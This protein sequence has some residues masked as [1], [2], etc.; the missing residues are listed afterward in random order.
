MGLPKD[1]RQPRASGSPHPKHVQQDQAFGRLSSSTQP[2]PQ[3]GAHLTIRSSRVRFAASFMRYRVTHRSAAAQ[4]GLTQ[5][6]GSGSNSSFCVIAQSERSRFSRHLSAADGSP[7]LASVTSLEIPH[8]KHRQQSAASDSRARTAHWHWIA[9]RDN[10]LP[11]YVACER[12]RF[13][14]HPALP[15]YS[16]K[17]TPLRSFTFAPALR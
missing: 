13:A 5:V 12:R 2:K 14:R 4:P 10:R 15:N 16:F 7:A 17:P 3:T 1:S 6:L 8:L 11:V 9:S